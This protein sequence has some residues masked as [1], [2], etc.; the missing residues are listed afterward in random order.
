M[1]FTQIES[2]Y[3]NAET[4]KQ[5][6]C[7]LYRASAELRDEYPEVAS[8]I[9]NLV[10]YI[11]EGSIIL[12]PK[13]IKQK[14]ISLSTS[15]DTEEPYQIDRDL[16]EEKKNKLYEIFIELEAQHPNAASILYDIVYFLSGD[17]HSTPEVIK[18]KLISLSLSES[19][20]QLCERFNHMT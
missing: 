11:N 3:M 20:L 18:Q 17:S 7:E 13:I 15:G 10:T 9:Y 1:K 16:I 8:F 6:S 2:Y 19:N 4:L 5:N 14:L 12:S